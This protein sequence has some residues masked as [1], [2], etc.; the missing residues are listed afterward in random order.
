MLDINP[1]PGIIDHRFL[2][3]GI[4]AVADGVQDIANKVQ[5]F[6]HQ[7][8]MITVAVGAVLSFSIGVGT[9]ALVTVIYSGTV[10]PV[11]VLLGALIGSF[12]L[13]VYI[14]TK[15][16]E[17]IESSRDRALRP[18]LDDYRN[19]IPQLEQYNLAALP[20]H[21]RDPLLLRGIE[22]VMRLLPLLR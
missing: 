15:T 17:L 1:I 20:Q 13:M 19:Y 2:E 22:D 7:N 11:M 21:L 4:Q 18:L 10:V 5:D 14:I 6:V 8:Q 16:A 9:V 3:N 12:A